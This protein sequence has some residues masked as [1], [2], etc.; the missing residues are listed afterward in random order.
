MASRDSSPV[1]DAVRIMVLRCRRVGSYDDRHSLL[2]PIRSRVDLS[3]RN[4]KATNH[5]ANVT[6]AD[7]I[8][9]RQRSIICCWRNRLVCITRSVWRALWITSS[10]LQLCKGRVVDAVTVD[11][12]EG[13]SEAT[14]P[15]LLVRNPSQRRRGGWEGRECPSRES[16]RPTTPA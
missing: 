7:L 13:G 10:S 8:V 3:D 9:N 15:G 2:G 1:S 11:L 5:I 4:A 14:V 16:G 6:K 12:K